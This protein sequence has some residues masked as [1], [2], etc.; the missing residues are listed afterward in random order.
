[1]GQWGQSTP[2]L[3]LTPWPH[4]SASGPYRKYSGVSYSTRPFLFEAGQPQETL[5][6]TF[7]VMG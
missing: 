1:M 7:Q 2:G 6:S 3:S 4:T 5:R